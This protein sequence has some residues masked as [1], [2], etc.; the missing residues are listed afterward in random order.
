MYTCQYEGFKWGRA[1][2]KLHNVLL[3][4]RVAG[5]RFKVYFIRGFTLSTQCVLLI[6]TVTSATRR[7]CWVDLTHTIVPMLLY[8]CM[9]ACIIPSQRQLQLWC[10][11]PNQW[12]LADHR[13]CIDLISSILSSSHSEVYM[14]ITHM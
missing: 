4:R 9:Y 12:F 14:I 7:F 5:F 6:V 10:D 11:N 3:K 1:C 13:A 2:A 8:V